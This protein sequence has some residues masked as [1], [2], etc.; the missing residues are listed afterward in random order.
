MYFS[1][2]K[3]YKSNHQ[4]IIYELLSFILKSNKKNNYYKF[5]SLPDPPLP[6]NIDQITIMIGMG[7]TNPLTVPVIKN[8]IETL[9]M[10]V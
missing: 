8:F 1:A 2:V 6:G 7:D 5:G 10:I 9:D 4:L 3:Q